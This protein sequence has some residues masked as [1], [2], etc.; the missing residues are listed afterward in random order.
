MSSLKHMQHFFISNM[1]G[2]N[3]KVQ[4]AKI[5]HLKTHFWQ[6]KWVFLFNM[7]C[8]WF[9]TLVFYIKIWILPKNSKNRP[10]VPLIFTPLKNNKSARLQT[11]KQYFSSISL[12]KVSY[13]YTCL[14]MMIWK[15]YHFPKHWKIQFFV[16][17]LNHV[18]W[19]I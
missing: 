5:V 15:K 14:W 7:G 4:K 18:F 2:F 13:H 3:L 19:G 10:P 8:L 16:F 1:L 9:Q 6:F 17:P 12:P 11:N